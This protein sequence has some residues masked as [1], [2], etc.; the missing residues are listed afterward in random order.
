M[1]VYLWLFNIKVYTVILDLGMASN[2]FIQ[3]FMIYASRLH[4]F[5]YKALYVCGDVFLSVLSIK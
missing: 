3:V 2:V 4:Q 5:C 1:S